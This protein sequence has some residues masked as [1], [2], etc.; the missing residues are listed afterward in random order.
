M[1]KVNPTLTY[2]TVSAARIV[3]LVLMLSMLISIL[4]DSFDNFL[5]EKH[6]IDCREKLDSVIEIQ[7]MKFF[8][9]ASGKKQYL[10]FLVHPYEDNQN[11]EE[12]QG[13]VLYMEKKQNIKI[14]R[15]TDEIAEVQKNITGVEKKI[16][17]VESKIENK[18][19]VIENKIAEVKKN[20]IGFEHKI[21]R[22]ENKMVNLGR[23]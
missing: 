10:H 13:K 19:T 6:I 9:R 8:K 1:N 12:W 11:T 18:I 2:I 3:N 5:L 16:T 7:K 4:G 14:Q 23:K 15:V 22:V 17:G 21:T 20:V